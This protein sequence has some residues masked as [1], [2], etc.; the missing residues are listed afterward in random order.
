MDIK[1]KEREEKWQKRWSD[2]NVWVPLDDGSKPRFYD[3]NEF[4][5]PSG[6][7]FHGGHML[8]YTGTDVLARYKRMKGFDV[9]YPMGFDSLGITAESYAVKLNKHPSVVIKELIE[10][11]KE[12]SKKMGWSINPNSQIATSDPEYVKW[13]QWMFI[14]FFKNGLA[15]KAPLNM[16]W[17]P[18]CRT[19]LTNEELDAGCCNRCGGKVE[20]KEKLQWNLRI[21]KYADRLIDDLK[22]VDYPE[23]VKNDQINWIGKSEGAEVDFLIEKYR[24]TVYTTRIDTIFGVCF[25]VVA[26]EHE[27]IKSLINKIQNK[28]EV[29]QYVKLA[30]QK[31]VLERT[32]FNKDKTGV[33]LKGIK[34]INPFNK[35][36]IPIYVSDY[37]LVNYGTGAIMAVPSEDDRD[38]EFA[39]KFNIK[40]KEIIDK[41]GCYINSN[42]LNGL[43]QK[44]AIKKA[45]EFGE[46]NKFAKKS[47]HYKITDW[48]FSRQVY[49][50][51]P[52]P[53]INCSHCG[54]VP[55]DEKDLPLMQ[56]YMKDFRPTEN[57][58]SPLAKSEEF[59]NTI[60]PVCG[61]KAKRETDTMPGWAGSSWY[62]L[63][64]LDPKNNSCFC[65]KKQ[66]ENWMPVDTYNGGNEHNTRHLLYS[67]F[68]HK[69]L[70]DLGYVNTIEPYKKRTTNGLLLGYDGKKM[71]KSKGNGFLLSE[72]LEET[73]ADVARL[74]VLSLGPW[75]TNVIW[76]SGAESGVKRFLKRV[77][78]FFDS[79]TDDEPSEK[80]EFL[81]NELIK[82]VD[83]R[84]NNMNFNTA[85]SA[86]MEFINNFDKSMP[87]CIY[88]TLIQL[89]NPFAPHITEEI[90]EKLGNKNMLVFEPF[91]KYDESKLLAKTTN[92]VISIN[93]KKITYYEEKI[94]E[95][96]AIIT[97]K[98]KKIIEKRLN[99]NK[100]LKIIFIKNKLINFVVK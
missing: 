77:E 84:I 31:T 41:D 50:G 88:K 86:M 64:Y 80:E 3:L 42:F 98:A 15:Y 36:E 11:F 33:E 91:P 72:K 40:N 79:L 46:K 24:L 49:W 53:I 89:L 82:N 43:N 75:D 25:C 67:R 27:I 7:G 76:S 38:S 10:K 54:Y 13:T 47:V 22:L 78:N 92:I 85:I 97:E 28:E 73:G 61:R 60:C 74:T 48:G 56:P 34:A 14:Q 93:G 81:I 17:C 29:L 69:A 51:E 26:P 21:T 83:Y 90:W 94:D 35:E 70:Y 39:K 18:N 96:E 12:S 1:I 19:T 4:P 5:F 9:L 37:V 65:S 8:N 87:R 63:R 59:V 68:W 16:N 55:V 95:K 66:M 2:A 57:G 62:F 20:Q 30:K 58:E 23:K 45:L 6:A 52:I 99:N 32:D 100:I 44:D 71:S